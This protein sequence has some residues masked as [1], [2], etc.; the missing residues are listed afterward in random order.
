MSQAFRPERILLDVTD[1]TNEEIRRRADAGETGPF[2]VAARRQTAGRGRQG[3]AWQSPD[4]NLSA[5][6]LLLFDGSPAEAALLGFTIALGVADTIEQLAPAR[7][8]SLKWP[9]DVLL[10]GRKVAGILLENFD[11]DAAR[12]LKIAIGIGINL[13]HHPDAAQ[14]NWP[15]TSIVVETGE[16]PAFAAAFD[17]LASTLD[18]RLAKPAGFAEVRE[19]WCAR[20]AHLGQTIEVR[21]PNEILNGRFVDLDAGGALVLEGAGGVRRIAAGD[22][23]FPGGG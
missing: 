6:R 13:S 4:G 19:E 2:W 7:R 5:S 9:N 10:E 16:P 14:T 11:R 8:V 23:H 15:P 17:I 1:S 3:R 12:R 22:V 18:E 21:L 20:A